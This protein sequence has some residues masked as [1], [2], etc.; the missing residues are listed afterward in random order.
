V[1]R[2]LRSEMAV[3]Y[4]ADPDSEDLHLLAGVGPRVDWNRVLPRGTATVGIAAAERRPVATS[5]D[6]LDVSRIVAG[7]LRIDRRPLDLAPIVLESVE[8]LRRDADAKSLTIA[9]DLEPAAGLLTGDAV[10][11][12][13][14]WSTWSAT[15]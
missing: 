7:K 6:L 1:Q 9:L 12:S 2:L 10:A 4:L 15:P 14:W 5:D 13:K 11:S 8:L 3:L